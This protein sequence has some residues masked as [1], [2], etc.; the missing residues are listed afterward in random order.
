MKRIKK[1]RIPLDTTS[2]LDVKIEVEGS[3]IKN[4]SLNVRCRIDHKWYEIY[5]V[6]TAHGYL[7]EQR[8][9]ISEKP[10]VIKRNDTLQNTFEHYMKQIKNHF[11]RYKSYYLESIGFSYD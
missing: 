7:H 11:E 4:F 8:Y 9:W 2:I 6:D 10:I 5:R 1:F 3:E